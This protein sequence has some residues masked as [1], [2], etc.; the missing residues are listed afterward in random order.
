MAITRYR[1]VSLADA[2]EQL[3]ILDSADDSV[4]DK[5]I[6]RA[7]QDIMAWVNQNLDDWTDTSGLPLVDVDGN[8]L[9]VGAKGHLDTNGDFVLDLDTAGN[10]IDNGI[11]IIPGPVEQ[12]ALVLVARMDN[13]REGDADLFNDTVKS[14]LWNYH[15][16]VSA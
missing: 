9:R 4:I 10:P 1:L 14:L 3:S 7:S 15:A 6:V 2:K 5:R 8:P 11:S 16:P 13:E 12:A